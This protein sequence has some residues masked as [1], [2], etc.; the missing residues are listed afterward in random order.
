MPLSLMIIDDEGVETVQPLC[1]RSVWSEFITWSESPTVPKSVKEFSS[2]G[3]VAD[4]KTFVYSL[5]KAVTDDPH[6]PPSVSRL[7]DEILDLVGVGDRNESL[8]IVE[9]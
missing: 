1:S 4:S 8:H 5:V 6:V 7:C 3:S 9:E 2:Q